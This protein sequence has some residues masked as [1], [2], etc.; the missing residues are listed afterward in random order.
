MQLNLLKATQTLERTMPIMNRRLLLYGAIT[1][2][3]LVSIPL[4]AGSF[5]G[6]ASFSD[7]PGFWGQLGAGF[8][9]VAAIYGYRMAR[10]VL[11]L[12]LD[13]VHLCAIVKRIQRSELPSG[14]E[15]Y[16]HLKQQVGSL[17]PSPKKADTCR[18]KLRQLIVNTFAQQPPGNRL[19]S[20]PAAK[21]LQ[22]GIA[23]GLL[24]F[25]ADAMIAPAF[26]E[27]R[28][29]SIRQG[30]VV[31]CRHYREFFQH[32][33]L[34]NAFLYTMLAFSFWLLL[35]PV[36]WVDNA[37][38]IGLGIWKYILGLILTF[39]IKASF[40]DPIVTAAIVMNLLPLCEN[41]GENDADE[42]SESLSI[43]E[44][45]E[46]EQDPKSQG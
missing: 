2:G 20:F 31:F 24:G 21:W 25:A 6:L 32:C 19:G 38:P 35:T 14:K 30:A 22:E 11:F 23:I 18:L 15:Q 8:G 39:W 41:M 27:M 37:L 1:F 5:Y 45:L 42:W 33:L 12:S 26:K 9:L 3:L 34:L 29:L 44:P 40:L 16:G 46:Q 4:G 28:L 13:L 43:L 36:G 7:N 17:F 10:P